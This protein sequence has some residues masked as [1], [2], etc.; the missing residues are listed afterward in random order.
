MIVADLSWFS[1]RVRSYLE[2]FESGTARTGGIVNP[3]IPPGVVGQ[4]WT[5]RAGCDKKI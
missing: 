1:N 2:G 5:I 4:W 3:S